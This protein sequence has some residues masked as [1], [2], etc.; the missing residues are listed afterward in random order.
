[1]LLPE[2]MSRIVIVGNKQ[3]LDE[4]TDALYS[5]KMIH[6]I[7]HTV[8]SDEGFS[9]GAPR[10][11]SE[12]ASERLLSLKAV[13][14]ELDINVTKE[15]DEPMSSADVRNEISQNRVE[16]IGKEVF[17]VLD[18]RSG[19]IQKITEESAKR[20]VY[21]AIASIPVDLDLYKGYRSIVVLVGS[22]KADP[23]AALSGLADSELFV[24]ADKKMIALFVKTSERE[25]ALR[26]LTDYEYTDISV[27]EGTGPVG[28]A[29]AGIN[30]KVAALSAEKEEA[31]KELAA[32][33]EKHGDDIIALDEEL[34]FEEMKGTM[35]LRIA[36]SSHS[37]VIDAWVPTSKTG[38]VVSGMNE[39]MDNNIYVEVMEDR[40]RSLHDV[41]HAEP[42]FKETPTK[43][44]NGPFARHFEHPVKLLSS[45]K[46]QE[47]DPTLILS[48]F[49]P[50]FFGFMVGDIGYAIPFI[51]L[52]A[53]G[54]KT[55][56]NKDFRAI[57][58]A[59]FF[60]G[61][62]TFIFG[63]F[64]YGEMFGMHF[65]GYATDN[66][67]TW[68]SLFGLHFPEW[69][70]NIFPNHGH[71]ISK[72]EDVTFL[73]KV[74]IYIGI[75]HIM[76]G[77]VIGFF[78]AKMQHGTKEA[79]FEKGG[80]IIT[81]VG[82]VLFAWSMTEVMISGVSFGD[83]LPFILAAAAMMV[84]GIAIS[85]KKEGGQAILEVPGL[86]GNILSYARLTAIGM[87]KAGMA[88][89]FNYI[90]ITMIA[91]GLGGIAG[92]IVGLLLFSFLH[93]VIWV[94]AILSAG[95]HSLRLQ[96]VEMMSKFFVG[97]GKE[98]EPLEIKR[99]NTKIVE[100]EV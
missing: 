37:F 92:I 73:L 9:I 71:G 46:Y 40:S 84:A 56:K 1:M 67:E 26:I 38:A 55:A 88:L 70:V 19:I 77:Y 51:I 54:L 36:T 62:W 35:P 34:S 97:G 47:I 75:I 58:M 2:P 50:L 74:S 18:R 29:V 59:L 44:N 28:D 96:Y 43:M 22:V 16:S 49:F 10:P 8:G 91:A 12:K 52:G 24:S 32:L 57:A 27:P 48:I 31:D 66:A 81:F 25:E 39:R 17:E 94:L 93:L 21:A 85:I 45:P 61:I 65:V 72:V 6:L 69:F 78:N 7:D 41:E 5:L 30:S 80:W 98:Y 53:Y 79:F 100:T 60:G 64:F 14:K 11:Y 23:T 4:A 13:E 87:S 76:L 95:L 63:F 89:A 20:D 99:K 83:M 3:R 86:F 33:K 68:M 15:S 90:S 42:R 82:L